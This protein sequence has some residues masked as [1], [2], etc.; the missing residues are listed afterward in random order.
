MIALFDIGNSRLKWQ[1]LDS[2]ESGQE[3]ATGAY[4]YHDAI[5]ESETTAFEGL[6]DS[7]FNSNDEELTLDAA[8]I[9]SVSSDKVN[10][11]VSQWLQ[12]TYQIKPEILRVASDCGDIHNAYETQDTLGVDR[13]LAAIA[14]REVVAE[15]DVIVVDAGTAINIELLDYNNVYQGGAI[16]PGFAMA[17]DSLLHSTSNIKTPQIYTEKVLG[18]N[19]LECV[20]SGVHFGVGGA[21]DRIIE[22]I[23]EL[24]QRD[25]HV[26]VTGGAA[27]Q[28]TPVMQHPVDIHDP[29]LIF[30]GILKVIRCEY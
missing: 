8:Y 26:V 21:V 17:H 6:F 29:F 5:T 18:K 11:L 20:N 19:T 7:S 12:T 23:T 10:Q 25:S 4:A 28:L 13:W 22:S 15:G 30:R 27:L 16:L 14:A 9:A 2:A 24:N 1:L 3:V